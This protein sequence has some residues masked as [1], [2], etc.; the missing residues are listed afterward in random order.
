MIINVWKIYEKWDD[1]G[2]LGKIPRPH[3][4]RVAVQLEEIEDRMIL[5]THDVSILRTIFECVTKI[6]GT[7]FT[8]G[9]TFDETHV[10]DIDKV[11]Y[12]LKD[13]RIE[14]ET[15]L[16]GSSLAYIDTD[17][18]VINE[19]TDKYILKLLRNKKNGGKL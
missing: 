19:A 5:E 6:Y 7:L 4:I 17:T 12:Y 15:F 8:L 13:S 11:I 10:V 2:L 1:S 18:E 16:S 3:K 9:K 14:I